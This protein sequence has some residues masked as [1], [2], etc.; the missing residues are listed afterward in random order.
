M[1][2]ALAGTRAGANGRNRIPPRRK[3]EKSENRF[4]RVARS[5][6]ARRIARRL[7]ANRN[8]PTEKKPPTGT[9]KLKIAEF[10]NEAFAY[11]PESYDPAI[12]YGVLV[13]L[14]GPG[15]Y[16]WEEVLAQWKPICDRYD[17]ILIAPKSA[18]PAMWM[19]GEITVRR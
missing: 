1:L 15:G 12:S 3:V 6:S 8:P 13:W 11:V 17:L 4:G 9:V 16:K 2:A 18:N 7:T 10:P 19:P 14:H 5:A